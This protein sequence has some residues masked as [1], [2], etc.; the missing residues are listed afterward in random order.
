MDSHIRIAVTGSP[1]ART[2]FGTALWPG[3][4]RKKSMGTDY[5]AGKAAST[6][7]TSAAKALEHGEVGMDRAAAHGL[8]ND[9]IAD[10]PVNE[11]GPMR[12]GCNGTKV[13]EQ[14]ARILAVHALEGEVP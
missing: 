13:N 6:I 5:S 1:E 14:L 8:R 12:R 3:L 11:T 2:S 10:R 4:D 9:F 7:G